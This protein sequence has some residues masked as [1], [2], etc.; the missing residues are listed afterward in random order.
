MVCP[1]CGSIAE[2]STYYRRTMCTNSKCNWEE[3]D[4]LDYVDVETLRSFI[5]RHGLT[6]L[7]LNE[8]RHNNSHSNITINGINKDMLDSLSPFV[9]RE[10]MYVTGN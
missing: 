2:Y 1:K 3:Y 5:R 8:V 6:D 10:A 4:T 7:L 9:Y